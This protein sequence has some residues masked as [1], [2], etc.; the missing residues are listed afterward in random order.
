MKKVCLLAAFPLLLLSASAQVTTVVYPLA[1]SR[2]SDTKE[3]INRIQTDVPQLLQKADVPGISIAL[4]RH[5]QLVWTGAFGLA[6][7]NTAR[8]VKTNTVFEAAS[9]SKVVFA[10][11]VLKLVDQG[12]IN[13]DTPLNKYLGNNYDVVNDDRINLIT[14]RHVLSH[15]SGF[16]NWRNTANES[17]PILFNPGEKFSYSGE[18]MVYLSRVVE[19]ITGLSFENFMQQYALQPLGMSS[20]SYIW[21][22]RYDTL[23][24]YRHDILGQLSGRNQP[25]NGKENAGQDHGNAAASLCTTAT[26]Y[27]TF[28]VALMNGTG[29]KKQTWQ[30]MMTPQVRVNPKYPAVAWGLGVGLE[31]M[32]EETNLWHWGDNGDAKAYFTASLKNKNAVVYFADGANG[33]SIVK[34][35]V[36]DG[37]GGEHPAIA[38][39]D[40]ETYHSPSRLLLKA[41]MSK[42]AAPALQDYLQQREDNKD[43]IS[44]DNMNSIGYVF[45]RMKR[46]DDA[47]AFFLQNTKDF[48]AS[49]NVWDSLGEAYAAQGDKPKAIAS[50]EKSVQLNPQNT[51]GA[52][53]LKKLKAQG[54]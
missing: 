5:G 13:L 6:N 45:L 1:A 25:E 51:N 27:A 48:P 28:L 39:L 37:L 43:S 42:G 16:P 12:K 21:R 49:W 46:A 19:K 9:L 11:A 54:K 23:K 17:L 30:Q 40:Y 3:S 52:D 22:N 44:E 34:E 14:A 4:V 35:L 47:I 20:S 7:V 29:L 53:T 36:N 15:T 41:A 32:P 50:Y 24:A 26:D 33:L 8:P 31:T 18:G 38:H 10:Y 2:L